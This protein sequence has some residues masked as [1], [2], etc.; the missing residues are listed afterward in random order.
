M[1]ELS[2]FIDESGDFG[3][4]DYR[5]PYYIIAM[6]MHDQSYDIS[7]DLEKLER[8]LDYIGYPNHCVHA[9]PIIRQEQEYRFE[10]M[11]VRQKMMKKMMSFLRQVDIK[12]KTVY[13][14]KKHISILNVTCP[15]LSIAKSIRQRNEY[16]GQ[17]SDMCAMLFTP[18]DLPELTNNVI[19]LSLEHLEPLAL[20]G[21]IAH[22]IR[23]IW[24]YKYKPELNTVRAQGY[25]DSLNHPAEIDADAFAICLLALNGLPLEQAG[26][27][28]S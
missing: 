26:E 15:D 21:I 9:G 19:Q 11:E 20:S 5:C 7:T 28:M 1:K 23:H 22:E 10:S 27:A 16:T 8:E 6:V 13:I 25:T 2:I 12:C 18:A 24:Q 17:L 4:Y 3:E 14:E